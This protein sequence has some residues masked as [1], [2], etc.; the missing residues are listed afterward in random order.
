MELKLSP[1]PKM[2][3]QK[4]EDLQTCT[5]RLQGHES[6]RSIPWR[7]CLAIQTGRAR[8]VVN[9]NADEKS[10]MSCTSADRQV[11]TPVF[12]ARRS[13]S[14]DT[15]HNPNKSP[16]R[17]AQKGGIWIWKRTLKTVWKKSW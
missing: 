4:Y 16:A 9:T 1:N 5:D 14:H 10:Q 13:L 6:A 2:T 12:K 7:V 17:Y 15:K 11:H 8:G 3:Q